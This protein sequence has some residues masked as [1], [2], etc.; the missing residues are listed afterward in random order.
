MQASVATA[1]A[2]DRG[3]T[4][5]IV[6]SSQTCTP[7]QITS[8]ATQVEILIPEFW[9]PISGPVFSEEGDNLRFWKLCRRYLENL[10]ELYP[11]KSVK[12]VS[13]MS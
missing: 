4:E 1:A 8:S 3:A 6:L 7:Q 13:P 5:C 11:S 12:T 10:Q 9:D 2:L